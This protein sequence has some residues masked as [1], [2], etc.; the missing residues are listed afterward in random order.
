[1]TA[2]EYRN[3]FAKKSEEQIQV[4]CVAWFRQTYPTKRMLLFSSLNGIKLAGGARQG[5]R[6]RNAGMTAG[7]AD[8]FLSIPSGD[9]AGLYIEMKTPKGRQQPNQKEFEEE[10]IKHGYGYV[11]PR[12]MEEF[13]HCVI[14]YLEKGEY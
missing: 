8:L 11:M 13:K 2:N 12:S 14:A 7:V 4:E 10:V 3:K 5:A 9:L 1:M 6:L